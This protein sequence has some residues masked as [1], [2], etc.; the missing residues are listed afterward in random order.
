MQN[1]VRFLMLLFFIAAGSSLQAE[2]LTGSIQGR[3]IDQSTQ[4]PLPGVNIIIQ[5]TNQGAATNEDGEYIIENIIPGR[6][7]LKAS[8]IGYDARVIPDVIVNSARP[9]IVD[10]SLSESVIE[11]QSVTV[12]SDYFERNPT[13]AN[14]ITSLS[15]EEIRRSPGGFEDVI[16]ALSVLPG[17][18]QADAGRNDLIV[19]GGAPSENLYIV[20]GFTVPNINH[21]GSQ[22]STG[23]PLSYIDLNYVKDVSFSTGGFPATYG[24]KL[25]SVMNITLGEGRRDRIGGKATISA[26][27][28]GLNVEG[29]LSPGSSFLFSARRSYLDFIFKSAGFGFVP[30]YYDVLSKFTTRLDQNKTFSVFFIGAFDNVRFF[31]NTSDQRYDNSRILGNDQIQYTGAVN[32][33]HIFS[34]GFYETGFNRNYVKYEFVQKDTLQNPI[35]L[36][37]SLE[38][39]NTFKFDYVYKTSAVQELNFGTNITLV[40]YEADIKMPFFRT[41]FGDT[42]SINSLTE[43]KNFIKS[44]FYAQYHRHLSEL[45]GFNA[46]IRMDYFNGIKN[47]ISVSPRFSFSYYPDMLTTFSIAGGIYHQNPSYIWLSGDPGN[48]DLQKIRS[49]QAVFGV[50]RILREDTRIKIEGFLK[51]YDDYPVSSLRPYLILSN[52]GAGFAGSEDNFSSF[53]PELLL[54]EGTGNVR[55]IELQIQK[56]SSDIPYYGIFS[57]TYSKSNF[58][59]LDGIERPGS[60][61]QRFI[62]NLSGGYIFNDAWEAAFKFR[63]ATGKPYTPFNDDG[64]QSVINYNNSRLESFHS[65][66]LRVDRRWN[67]ETWSLV[68]YLDIQNIYNKKNS[69]FVRWD[70]KTRTAE[71]NSSIGILPSIGITAEL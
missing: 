12:T 70:E 55:G 51:Y 61:D 57:F 59:A 33:K 41:T 19:R 58:K 63:F 16:R 62:L 14:S 17:I 11:L 42:L 47:K 68:T 23:G 4:S 38:T 6:Y 7:S 52:T 37:N 30:E 36:N 39:E 53:A 56:K 32:F 43:Q 26:S 48:K 40:E 45:F 50:E 10:I 65:L 18:A 64:S 35:F 13:I 71:N 34:H 69:S 5:N 29:P 2:L 67:F 24:D 21:F 46:G 3:V 31:N 22:G 9:T 25:S 27:Q 28:F 49:T 54:S 8:I 44:G 66:D 60:F 20:D 15:Y 1:A